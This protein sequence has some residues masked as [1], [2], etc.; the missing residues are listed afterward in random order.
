MLI[1][2]NIVTSMNRS[3]SEVYKPNVAGYYSLLYT[4]L[5]IQLAGLKKI[6]YLS[7]T[8]KL[9][10]VSLRMIKNVFQEMLCLRSPADG[11]GYV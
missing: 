3:D 6:D 4:S 8:E 10:I 5:P 9:C 1:I 11:Q 2:T 7:M